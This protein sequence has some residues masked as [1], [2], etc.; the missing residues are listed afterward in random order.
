MNYSMRKLY[1]GTGIGEA[2]GEDVPTHNTVWG[3]APTLF[4]VLKIPLH[5]VKSC[6]LE[7]MFVC[8]FCHNTCIIY[9]VA[10]CIR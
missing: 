5:V 7:T 4:Q 6:S 9:S 1:I 10:E 8:L 3:I 2:V